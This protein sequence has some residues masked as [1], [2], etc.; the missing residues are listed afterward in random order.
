MAGMLRR[1]VNGLLIT[2]IL[3]E[4]G[5]G[6]VQLWLNAPNTKKD[7]WAEWAECFDEPLTREGVTHS[8]FCLEGSGNKPPLLLLHELEGLT[9]ETMHY[10]TELSNDFT[11]YLPMLF[12]DRGKQTV[13]SGL[14]GMSAYWLSGEWGIPSDGSAPVV[15]WLRAVVVEIQAKHRDLPIRIIGN[16]MTG[17]FPL[18]LLNEGKPSDPKVE[19]VVIAQPALPMRFFWW[20]TKDDR[21]SLGL[22]NKDL[23]F[24][25]GSKAKILTM[26]FETDG[27]SHPEKQNTLRQFGD[28]LIATEI[29][30]K[31]YQ[32]KGEHVKAHSV[33]IGER[34]TVGPIRELSKQKREQVREFFLSSSSRKVPDS[35]CS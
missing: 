11:V 5:C 1:L 23:M 28:R 15:E 33:L 32:P 3:L 29:C 35:D 2:L 4:T 24:A 7:K 10:A 34:D 30:A 6:A 22:S 31:N 16:C 14:K 20:Q 25:K 21:K 27:I 18:A 13:L 26:R 12:G 19:S 8:V 17:A 9:E